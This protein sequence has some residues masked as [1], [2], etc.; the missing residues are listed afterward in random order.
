MTNVK[1]PILTSKNLNI[2]STRSARKTWSSIS[3]RF[4]CKIWHHSWRSSK[5]RSRQRSRKCSRMLTLKTRKSPE[6]ELRGLLMKSRWC[7]TYR[8]FETPTEVYLKRQRKRFQEAIPCFLRKSSQ[9][10][11]TRST[12]KLVVYHETWQSVREERVSCPLVRRQSTSLTATSTWS[13]TSCLVSRK[14]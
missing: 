11:L 9:M 6:V 5:I 10:R 3:G 7:L 4:F 14:Q 1:S 13:L 8:T 2:S 12:H